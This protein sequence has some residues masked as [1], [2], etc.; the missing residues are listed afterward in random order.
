MSD[1]IIQTPCGAV[2]GVQSDGI[3]VFRGIPYAE[4][5]RF[6]Y[7]RRIT[8]WEGVLDASSGELDCYQYG[9]FRD[10]SKDENDFYYR[11]F[12]SERSFQY[13][14]S[15]MTL[16]IIA[17][18][19]AKNCPVLVFIH[20]GGHETGT[21]GELPYGTSTEYA[22]RNVILV[23]VGYRLNVFSLYRSANFGLYD[24]IEA[25]RWIR[26]NIYAFGGDPGAITMMG[27][28]A[29]AMS[30]MDLCYSEELKGIV[31]GAVMIS[32]GGVIPFVMGP[33]T[34]KQSMTFWDTV[35]K[36]AGA[37]DEEELKKVPADVLWEAWFQES[38]AHYNYHLVQPGIDGRIIPGQPGK[39]K[40]AGKILDIPMVFGVT[41][42][43]F[44]PL[45]LL[46]LAY[47]FG[48]WSGRK[49]RSPVYGYFFDRTLPGNCYQAFHAADLWYLFG[50]MDKSWRPFEET[51]RQ[52]CRQLAD[53][54]AN[55]VKT[56]NP[57]GGELPVWSPL[58]ESGK[59]RNLDGVS[60]KMVSHGRCLR[61][62]CQVLRREK[63]PL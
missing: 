30:V 43:D 11:E 39:L 34:P 50:N 10:E 29:G 54:V 52:L 59:F 27:Q 7:P 2:K 22:R 20:G 42:Q 24:Q 9:S 13:V 45:V 5:P 31:R 41:S 62:M 19:G 53:Y 33:W 14:E 48:K 28:S 56:G 21:V 25:I 32:G 36:R 8:H 6:A 61:R 18:S 55:F 16:N 44:M 15:P 17:P 26:D 37:S 49:N 63:G 4:M 1:C 40:R 35:C 38:R 57:N 46:E 23:S 58:S 3:S 12:R 60:E 51:D 47:H